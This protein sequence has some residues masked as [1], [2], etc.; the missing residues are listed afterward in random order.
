MCFSLSVFAWMTAV[1]MVGVV[2]VLVG[3]VVVVVFVGV[4]VVWCL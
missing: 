3:V 1:E 2:V 4:L